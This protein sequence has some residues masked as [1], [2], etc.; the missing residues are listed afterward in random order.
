MAAEMTSV[1]RACQCD[2]GDVARVA[3]CAGT[4]QLSTALGNGQ[5]L[6]PR[7]PWALAFAHGRV[8]GVFVFCLVVLCVLNISCQTHGNGFN[9]HESHVSGLGPRSTC[10]FFLLNDDMVRYLVVSH[11]GPCLFFLPLVCLSFSF[12]PQN[13]VTLCLCN[14]RSRNLLCPGSLSTTIAILPPTIF[15]HCIDKPRG[16]L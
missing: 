6:L 9:R 14:D 13:Y 7:I 10:L 2:P 12:M 16:R 3:W 5:K 11:P 8:H 1:P 4:T 15:L